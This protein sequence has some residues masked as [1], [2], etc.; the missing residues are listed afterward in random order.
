MLCLAR[1]GIVISLRAFNRFLFMNN[2]HEIYVDN[3][4]GIHG[5]V[6]DKDFDDV[7]WEPE[8]VDDSD[9]EAAKLYG[10]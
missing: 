9:N 8:V 4:I 3:E 6:F 10:L 2:N 5:E 1:R 7:G